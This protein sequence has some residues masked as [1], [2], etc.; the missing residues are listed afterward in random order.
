MSTME[1]IVKV[2]ITRETRPISQQGF[3]TILIVGPNATFVNRINYYTDLTSIA[4]VLTGG[5]ADEEYLAAEAIF[6]QNPRVV[7]VAIGRKDALDADYGVA[8]DAILEESRDFYGVIL[9]DRTIAN[10]EDVMDWVQANERIC[11]MAS[12]GTDIG[13]GVIDIIDETEAVDNSSIAYYAKTN[14]L[15]RTSIFYSSQAATKFVD[16]AYLG[17]ILPLTPGSY[18]GMFKTLAGVPVDAVTPTQSKNVHDKYAN[19]YEEIGEVNIVM[20]GFVSTGE[21]TDIIVFQDWLKAR[22]TE[23]VFALLVNEPKVPYTDAGIA[24][25]ETAVKQILQIGQ[26]N[27]GISPLSFNSNVKPPQQIG[28]YYTTVPILS[29]IPLIDKT[30]RIL[31]QVNFTAWLAGAIHNVEINGVLTL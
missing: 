3:G 27:G 10:Q 17:K 25:I 7:Q 30:A 4:A 15:D 6:S 26:D 31:K 12:A 24:S 19:T 18:T 13:G 29:S 21:Y 9:A 28:G 23:N 8:L 11:C 2:S 14:S 20:Q 16:A 1:Q 5:V 22:I